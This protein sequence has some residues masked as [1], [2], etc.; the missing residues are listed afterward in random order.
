MT[1][2]PRIALFSGPLGTI[3]NTAPLITSDKARARY[4]LPIN[5]S[6]RFDALRPQ[7]LAAPVTVY[8]EQFS[9]HPLEADAAALYAPPDGF[10]DGSGAFHAERQSPDDK[11]VYA[12]ELRP[13][14]GLYPLPYFGRQADGSAWDATG[15][16]P[17]APAERS[18]QTFLPDASRLVEEIDRFGVGPDGHASR[19]SAL[20]D[21]DHIRVLPSGGYSHGLAEAQR[22][23]LGEG[24]IDPEALGIDYFPYFP[25]MLRRDPPLASLARILDIVSATLSNDRY[26]GAVWLESSIG[27][28]ET[29]YWLG[30]LVD[31]AKPIVAVCAPESPHGVLGNTGDRNLVDAVSYITSGVW[32]DS[33]GHDRVGPVLIDS[34]RILSARESM[35]TDARSGGLVGTGSVGV[36]GNIA[37]TERPHLAM[38]PRRRSTHRSALLASGWPASVRGVVGASDGGERQVVEVV[39]RDPGGRVRPEV[40]PRVSIAKNG[41]YVVDEERTV[42]AWL[43]GALGQ[44]PLAGI[45]AE[46][47]TPYGGMDMATEAVLRRALYSGV[48]YVKVGRGNPEG[49]VTRDTAPFGIAGGDLASPKARL[50]LIA[51]LLRFGAPPPA[52][53]PTRPTPDEVAAVSGHLARFQ[54]AFD[55]H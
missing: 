27:L 52:V 2:R 29:A 20:A 41:R 6:S 53:D 40:L 48:P 1:A 9:A 51:C 18:R 42:E 5:H 16:T 25:P 34:G 21:F 35:K 13:D 26:D 7:R 31:T 45:V 36:I 23:D 28:E 12:I 44:A 24:D 55:E 4:G 38:V 37:R 15:S 47:S 50:L 39:L 17:A 10:V 33:A 14:D 30:L 43:A 49:Y 32:A 3:E 11:P 8:V 22:S 46:G 54:E 19:L